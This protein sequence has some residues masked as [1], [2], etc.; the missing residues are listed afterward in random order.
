MHVEAWVSPLVI[1]MSDD[2]VELPLSVSAVQPAF[3]KDRQKCGKVPWSDF[4]SSA[5]GARV[6]PTPAAAIAQRS[7][8]YGSV[9]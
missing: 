8:Y 6:K 7:R 5:I 9:W 4:G 2:G 3:P 1:S